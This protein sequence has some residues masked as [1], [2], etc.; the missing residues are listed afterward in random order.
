MEVQFE[1]YQQYI[2]IFGASALLILSFMVFYITDLVFKD[3]LCVCRFF[4]A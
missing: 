1:K 4:M 3:T 2:P